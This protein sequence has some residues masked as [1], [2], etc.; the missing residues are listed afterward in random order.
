MTAAAAIA[1]RPSAPVPVVGPY[2]PRLEGGIPWYEMEVGVRRAARALGFVPCCN[3]HEEPR[4]TLVVPALG[5]GTI[6][7]E[8]AAQ[9]RE[10]GRVL[11]AV[12]DLSHLARVMEARRA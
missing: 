9:R 6:D 2:D 11:V 4:A 7:S 3:H 8:I 10:W 5:L 12:V 1:A